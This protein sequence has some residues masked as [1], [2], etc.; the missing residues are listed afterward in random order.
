MASIL[1][2]AGQRQNKSANPSSSTDVQALQLKKPKEVSNALDKS[3]DYAKD[4]MQGADP[5]SQQIM[6]QFSEQSAAT[7]AARRGAEAQ[8]AELS[9]ASQS[10]Q[11]I[12]GQLTNRDIE[13]QTQQGIV[14]LASDLG[15]RADQQAGQLASIGQFEQQHQLDKE[16]FEESKEQFDIT[17]E[18]NQEQI[19]LNEKIFGLDESKYNQTVAEK[20]YNNALITEDITTPEGLT[21]IKEAAKEAGFGD[22]N[23]DE[24]IDATYDAEAK[25]AGVG[26]L[27][28]VAIYMEEF[29]DE[30]T[31]KYSIDK[32]L[33]NEN[34]QKKLGDLWSAENEGLGEEFDPSNEDHIK[35]AKE[36]LGPG[37]VTESDVTYN[38]I[39]SEREKAKSGMTFGSKAEEKAYDQ[40]TQSLAE[41]AAHGYK[42][43]VIDGKAVIIDT[44]TGEVIDESDLIVGEAG[45]IYKASSD[46]KTVIIED[47]DGV[48]ATAKKNDKGKWIISV[49]GEDV[50]A[51]DKT[52]KYLDNVFGEEESSITDDLDGPEIPDGITEGGIWVGDDGEVYTKSGGM[53]NIVDVTAL[54][55]TS[56]DFKKLFELTKK[57]PELGKTLYDAGAFTSFPTMNEKGGFMDSSGGRMYMMQG[58]SANK[59]EKLESGI[60]G[61][62]PKSYGD[63]VFFKDFVILHDP[64]GK[65]KDGE[66]VEMSGWHGKNRD[67]LKFGELDWRGHKA[68]GRG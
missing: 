34:I 32:A 50:E 55:P 56:S 51:P 63:E 60:V 10:T 52:T 4:V 12:L 67:L 61:Y 64:T 5:T 39:M 1:Q 68:G 44:A 19:D 20:A 45:E 37:F 62:Y 26:L 53:A 13:Q 11:N 47:D 9:G 25:A 23:M 15:A 2:Q 46:G 43:D 27:N 40:V 33:G 21:K 41:M 14:G 65:F 7:S 24:L 3:K 18:Q 31:S 16:K 59:V 42:S 22:L 49:N 8:R 48:S 58:N 29:F 54:T 38:S 30:S 35:W 6:N 57:S 17:S 36:K 66:T 28:D